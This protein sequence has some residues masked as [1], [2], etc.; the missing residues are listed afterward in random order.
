MYLLDF[1][2]DIQNDL[3]ELPENVFIE[4]DKYFEKFKIN[5]YKYTQQLDNM[6]GMDLRGYSK[7]YVYH[8]KYRIVSRI[9]DNAVQ[10]VEVIAVDK[11]DDFSVYKKAFDRIQKMK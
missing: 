10:I 2:E 3:D 1:H 9:I 11:R 5:P 4:V 8:H 6:Y 7:T